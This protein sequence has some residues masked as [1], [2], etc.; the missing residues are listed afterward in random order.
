[1]KR[2]VKRAKRQKHKISY[3]RI[4]DNSHYNG[5]ATAR[6]VAMEITNSDG[7]VIRKRQIPNKLVRYVENNIGVKF[8][9]KPTFYTYEPK[10]GKRFRPKR[11][12]GGWDGAFVTAYNLG[13]GKIKGTVVI[14]PKSHLKNK[15]LKENVLVHELA[16][17]LVGQHMIQP[18]KKRRRTQ[19]STF[20]HGF[21][22]AYEKK[23]LSKHGMTAPQMSALAKRLFNDRESWN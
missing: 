19:I 6:N 12:C 11:E 14:L 22:L 13:D 15:A 7:L 5:P 17:T 2:K 21:G 16:E 9:R 8:K 23:H 10:R 20:E 3:R 1:M 18:H 4:S